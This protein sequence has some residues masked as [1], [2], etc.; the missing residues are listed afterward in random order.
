MFS[1]EHTVEIA[2]GACLVALVAAFF[3]VRPF[4]GVALTKWTKP[5]SPRVGRWFDLAGAIG[6]MLVMLGWFV[7]QTAQW[8]GL[9]VLSVVTGVV[10]GVVAMLRRTPRS[11]EGNPDTA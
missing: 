2:V 7:P 5:W 11:Q 8:L 4:Y 10:L 3:A 9:W 1:G 6:L